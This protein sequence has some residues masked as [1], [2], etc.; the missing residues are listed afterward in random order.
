MKPIDLLWTETAQQL[1]REVLGLLLAY[2][3]LSFHSTMPSSCLE[4][5]QALIPL[6][7]NFIRVYLEV[8]A[9]IVPQKFST[10]K[11]RPT[12][13]PS[14]NVQIDVNRRRPEN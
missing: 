3:S 10:W 5:Q 12:L 4:N 7:D 14:R 1:R 11:V 8:V 2:A 9:L 6:Y 13:L